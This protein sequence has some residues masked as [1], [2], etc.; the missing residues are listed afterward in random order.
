MIPVPNKWLLLRGL[1]RESAHWGS[2]P[3]MLAQGLGAE[4]HCLDLPGMGQAIGEKCPYSVAEIRE[5]VRRRWLELSAG[6]HELVGGARRSRVV[7]GVLSISLGSMVSMDWTGRYPADFATQVLIN[8]SAADVAHPWKR[9]SWAQLPRVLRILGAR[10]GLVRELEVLAMTSRFH[11]D[12][13]EVAARW[14][15]LAPP[16]RTFIETG[17]A[18]IFAAARFRRPRS[19]GA[20]TLVLASQKDELVSPECSYR[21]SFD[22][23][24]PMLT[25]LEAGHDLPLDDPNWIVQQ[26]RSWLGTESA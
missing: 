19:F 20:C 12:D 7:W 23:G 16:K 17:V 6:D 1:L 5:S 24:C 11:K 10:D 3:Q 14:A 15:A 9:F 13:R 21:I 26:V 4:V 8:P 18:Q 2:F 22:A 25:H